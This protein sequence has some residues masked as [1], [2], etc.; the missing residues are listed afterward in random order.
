[1][2]NETF[3]EIF[4]ANYKVIVEIARRDI[5]GREL[6]STYAT[7]DELPTPYS[8]PIAT[9]A[10]LGGV[11]IGEGISISEAGVISVEKCSWEK[12]EGKPF[13]SVDSSDFTITEEKLTINPDRFTTNENL[14]EKL[15]DYYTQ[16]EVDKIISALKAGMYQIVESL[17]STGE[18]GIIYLVGSSTPY[19]M[20]IWE[21]DSFIKIG[22]TEISL[23]GYVKGEGLEVDKLVVGNSGSSIKTT[24]YSIGTS[25]TE[26]E[27]ILPTSKAV[28]DSLA[29]KQDKLTAGNGI[30]IEDNVISSVITAVDVEV[31][32]G[33]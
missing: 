14:S 16:S 27:T 26:S 3:R 5:L 7:K 13:A 2:A 24:A 9:A 15:K 31:N 17:P 22:D 28:Y 1:M 8:L 12:I 19:E 6:T 21:N 18:D 33:E 25:I 32:I 30:T 10:T 4:Y 11:M 29:L 23:D 20:Y